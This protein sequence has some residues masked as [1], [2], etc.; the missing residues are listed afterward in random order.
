MMQRALVLA[1]VVA[2]AEAFAPTC[3]ASVRNFTEIK[4]AGSAALAA[5]A[6]TSRVP[7]FEPASHARLYLADH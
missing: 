2:I 1:A 7:C 6:R 4:W 3:P 5:A